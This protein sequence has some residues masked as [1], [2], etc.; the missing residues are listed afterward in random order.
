[1][2]ACMSYEVLSSLDRLATS[3]FAEPVGSRQ[4]FPV[5]GSDGPS[6]HALASGGAFNQRANDGVIVPGLLVA[7]TEE[8]AELSA[9]VQNVVSALTPRSSLVGEITRPFGPEPGQSGALIVQSRQQQPLSDG[10]GAL[11]HSKLDAAS[12]HALVSE[13]ERLDD[14]LLALDRQQE[15]IIQEMGENAEADWGEIEDSGLADALE[16]LMEQEQRKMSEMDRLLKRIEKE[17]DP[18]EMS[19][20]DLAAIQRIRGNIYMVESEI[21][22]RTSVLGRTIG[23]RGGDP[24]PF[25]RLLTNIGAAAGGALGVLMRLFPNPSHAH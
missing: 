5:P 1:M 7:R 2:G 20:E 11:V 24:N 19:L 25:L 16:R 17:C 18:A 8:T 3:A 14:E 13:L 10:V 6:P 21:P 4:H 9:S 15:A 22:Q 12:C 23:E